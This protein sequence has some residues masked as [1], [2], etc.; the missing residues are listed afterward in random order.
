MIEV[1]PSID[2]DE[3]ELQFQFKLASGPGGQNVN[4]VATAAELRFDAA[5]SP[6]LPESVRARLL[7][8]AGSRATQAG[9]LLITARRFRSQERNRQDAIERLI[10][11]IQE[12]AEIPKPRLKTRPS[13]AAKQRRMDAKRRIG[14]KKQ[15]RRPVG[16]TR[17]GE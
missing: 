8:L 2:L 7:T 15:T 10:A 13:R 1:I 12:A 11:L 4:K 6:S 14:D 17:D 5:R 16:A 3:A 9:E